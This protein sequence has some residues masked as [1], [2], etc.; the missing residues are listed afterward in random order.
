MAHA[1]CLRLLLNRRRCLN[2]QTAPLIALVTTGLVAARPGVA[3]GSADVQDAFPSALRDQALT[4]IRKHCPDLYPLV[5][6]LYK[7]ESRHTI[8]AEPENDYF[9]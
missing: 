4:K 2:S 6:H 1:E 9:L 8:E 5:Y 7:G 3:V